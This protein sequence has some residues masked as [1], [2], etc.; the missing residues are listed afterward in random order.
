MEFIKKNY[1]KI[2][3]GFILAGLIGMLIFMLFYI[4][5]DD[6][7][8]KATASSYIN[9]PAKPL[10]DLDL[11]TESNMIF[12]LQSPYNL[13]FDKT[14]KLF[15]SMEWQKAADGSLIKISSGNEVG[16]NAVIVTNIEPLYL[17]L[18]LDSVKTNEFGAGYMVGIEKQAEKNPYKRRKQQHYVSKGDKNET[19]ELVNVQGAPEN[20]DALVVKLADSGETVTIPHDQPYQR[21]DGYAA[22][23]R[24]DPEKKVFSGQRIGDKFS[25]QRIGDKV[26]FGGADYVVVEVNQNELILADQS[27]QR[28]YSLP[29]TP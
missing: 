10:P 8:M 13:D 24:Y 6:A 9:H 12:R 20:P 29:F 1:E 25:G 11:T 2:L 14:N 18:T 21:V 16:P 4:A 5:A 17:V 23:F 26:S 15:N 27:N 22:F 3:L 28:K 7:A 19:F